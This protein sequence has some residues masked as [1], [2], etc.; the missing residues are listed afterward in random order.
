[1]SCNIYKIFVD[2][3]YFEGFP[4]KHLP[5]TALKLKKILNFFVLPLLEEIK[6]QAGALLNL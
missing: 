6:K 3:Q 2:L 4:K 1:M 5:K